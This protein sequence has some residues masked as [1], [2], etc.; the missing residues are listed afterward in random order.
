VHEHVGMKM[1]KM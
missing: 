1:I